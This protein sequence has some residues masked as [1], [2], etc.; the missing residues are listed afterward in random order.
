MNEII[1]R[2]S[3]MRRQLPWPFLHRRRALNS[4][5]RCVISLEWGVQ[6]GECKPGFEK[7]NIESGA[8]VGD[9]HVEAR[10]QF[11]ERMEHGRFFIEVAYEVLKDVEFVVGKV[12]ETYKKGTDSG[13]ALNAGRFSVEEDDPIARRHMPGRV[14]EVH[15]RFEVRGRE[16]VQANLA[17]E[18][19]VRM[20]D[21]NDVVTAERC[22]LDFAGREDVGGIEDQLGGLF[23]P[24][25]TEMLQVIGETST[26]GVKYLL[27]PIGLAFAPLIRSAPPSPS[28]RGNRSSRL[29]LSHWERE[30]RSAG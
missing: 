5:S 4:R 28:G 2:S 27:R 1:S 18:V 29:S 13:T 15:E 10:H 25:G 22:R 3:A 8:I 20:D 6:T 24:L 19:I 26:L 14:H 9:D 11:A 16:A 17:V 7:R 21:A 30:A 23:L 12:A